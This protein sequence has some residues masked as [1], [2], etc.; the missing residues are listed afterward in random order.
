MVIIKL[1]AVSLFE[2]FKAKYFAINLPD[3]FVYKTFTQ[4][5]YVSVITILRLS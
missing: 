5:F 4:I 2:K 3:W 1:G